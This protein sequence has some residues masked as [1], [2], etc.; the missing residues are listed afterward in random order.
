MKT[1]EE[2]IT[3]LKEKR[4]ALNKVD[5]KE[6]MR[7]MYDASSFVTELMAI[8]PDELM[9]KTY[10]EHDWRFKEAEKEK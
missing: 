4:P 8:P 1:A 7:R 2:V 6:Y 5:R 9:R 10:L 3:R